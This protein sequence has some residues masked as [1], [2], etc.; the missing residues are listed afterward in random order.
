MIVLDA[1]PT[2]AAKTVETKPFIELETVSCS[3]LSSP[4]ENVEEVLA[5]FAKGDADSH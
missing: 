3:G 5:V 2:A 1:L 4:V